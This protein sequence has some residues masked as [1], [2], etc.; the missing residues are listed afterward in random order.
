MQAE[1]TLNHKNIGKAAPYTAYLHKKR[2]NNH[3]N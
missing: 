1:T 3:K 2:N